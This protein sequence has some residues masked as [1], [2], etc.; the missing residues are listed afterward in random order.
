MSRKT[1]HRSRRHKK[2][3]HDRRR[4]NDRKWFKKHPQEVPTACQKCGKSG[5]PLQFHHER[6]DVPRVGQFLCEECH[7]AIHG[8]KPNWE[9]RRSKNKYVEFSKKHPKGE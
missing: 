2:T 8:I 4:E 7:M 6:Y 3:E 5:V 1:R 9:K